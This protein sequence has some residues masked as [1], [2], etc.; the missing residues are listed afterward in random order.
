MINII[1]SLYDYILISPRTFFNLM[2]IFLNYIRYSPGK[3]YKIQIKIGEQSNLN[4]R[5]RKVIN[6]AKL[7]C[8][9]N[10]LL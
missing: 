5:Y 10:S 9:I 2:R 3:L 7:K 1:Y 8:F 4:R 6:G